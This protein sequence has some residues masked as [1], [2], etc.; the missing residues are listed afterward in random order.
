MPE[1]WTLLVHAVGPERMGVHPAGAWLIMAL[2]LALDTPALAATT[3]CTTYEEKTMQRLQT[4]CDDGTRAVSTW[5]RT[6]GGRPQARGG[7]DCTR[8]HPSAGARGESQVAPPQT[9]ARAP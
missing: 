2:L 5:N 8:H 7:R 9:P 3:R 6:M 1:T 4:V